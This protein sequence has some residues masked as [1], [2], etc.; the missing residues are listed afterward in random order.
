MIRSSLAVP[1]DRMLQ[2][3]TLLL[4]QMQA[5]TWSAT[6]RT[7]ASG[8]AREFQVSR[9]VRAAASGASDVQLSQWLGYG[10]LMNVAAAMDLWNLEKGLQPDFMS[11]AWASS[12]RIPS[13]RLEGWCLSE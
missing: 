7:C 5:P 8:G 3:L 13:I 6:T 2:D 10:M 1:T 9:A 4:M 12:S 11:C